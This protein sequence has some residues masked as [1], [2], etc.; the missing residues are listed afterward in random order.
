MQAFPGWM[1]L[2]FP[3]GGAVTPFQPRRNS[4]EIPNQLLWPVSFQGPAEATMYLFEAIQVGT[5]KTLCHGQ[6]K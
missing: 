2:Q 5:L 6:S 3:E 4:S 1:A